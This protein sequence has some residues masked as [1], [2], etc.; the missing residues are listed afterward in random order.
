[1]SVFT[2]PDAEFLVVSSSETDLHIG[3]I[4]YNQAGIMYMKCKAGG[5]IADTKSC[6]QWTTTAT[7]SRGFIVPVVVIGGVDQGDI[8]QGWNQTGTSLSSGN[9]FWATVGPIVEGVACTGTITAGDKLYSA[10]TG[11]MTTTAGTETANVGV[12]ITA[13]SSSLVSLTRRGL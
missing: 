12:A 3:N 9:F 5:T 2:L 1:M 11:A 13:D 6:V 4:A 8:L 7:A 10:N